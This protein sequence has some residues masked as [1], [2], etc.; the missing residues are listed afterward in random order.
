VSGSQGGRI[1]NAKMIKYCSL[2]AYQS[3]HITRYEPSLC[4]RQFNKWYEYEQADICTSLTYLNVPFFPLESLHLFLTRNNV[5]TVYQNDESYKLICP[6]SLTHY[7]I[8]LSYFWRQSFACPSFVN[9]RKQL[10]NVFYTASVDTVVARKM[11][12][13]D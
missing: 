2:L 8:R 5:A 3:S 13:T 6:H 1:Y 10:F 7:N 9:F 11:R 4:N 12:K